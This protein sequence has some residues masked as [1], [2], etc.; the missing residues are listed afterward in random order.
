MKVVWDWSGTLAINNLQATGATELLR[1]IH[2]IVEMQMILTNGPGNH[3]AELVNK[4]GWDKYFS[5]IQGRESG[6]LKP[7][8]EA[9]L[10]ILKD[11]KIDSYHDVLMIGDSDDDIQCAINTGCRCLLVEN[12]N[13]Y[14]SVDDIIRLVT[15]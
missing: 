2:P 1:K 4:F 5:R 10:N 15:D 13:L 7:D 8:K 12:G 3:T 9:M 6:L 11:I 14:K